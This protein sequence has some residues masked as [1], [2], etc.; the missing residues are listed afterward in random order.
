MIHQHLQLKHAMF[1]IDFKKEDICMAKFSDWF[2]VKH[3]GFGEE[4]VGVLM[5]LAGD[6]FHPFGQVIEATL[7]AIRKD[8][9]V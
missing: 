2:L 4:S 5:F 6:K 8:M 7:C 3:K 9:Q 1:L